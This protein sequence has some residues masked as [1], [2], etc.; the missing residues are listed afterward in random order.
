MSASMLCVFSCF[1]C[2]QMLQFVLLLLQVSEQ[3][4]RLI[5]MYLTFSISNNMQN[6]FK[7]E[8]NEHL[9]RV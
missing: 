8:F 6:M 1:L 5:F 9:G 3:C 7:F 2:I 4:M